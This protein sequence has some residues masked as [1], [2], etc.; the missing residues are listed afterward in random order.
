MN[1]AIA[2]DVIMFTLT[3]FKF[4]KVGLFGCQKCRYRTNPA[5][6][7]IEALLGKGR[8]IL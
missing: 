7:L 3:R 8:G 2:D 4:L 5:K 1:I 6:N